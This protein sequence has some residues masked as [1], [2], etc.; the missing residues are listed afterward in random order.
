MS[1]M[2]SLRVIFRYWV[3][4]WVLHYLMWLLSLNFLAFTTSFFL[5]SGTKQQKQACMSSE[6]LLA[7]TIK[8]F[9]TH[10]LMQ[11][12]FWMPWPEIT[13]LKINLPA[14][15]WWRWTITVCCLSSIEGVWSSSQSKFQSI[16][17]LFCVSVKIQRWTYWSN[18][19]ISRSTIGLCR[20]SSFGADLKVFVPFSVPFWRFG[21]RNL[22][23]WSFLIP[24]VI[25]NT[26]NVSKHNILFKWTAI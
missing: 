20:N 26:I 19:G 22:L 1:E 15:N 12:S 16:N 6:K 23:R 25:C 9:C 10:R 24:P 2:Q 18:P 13:S 3:S 5:K 11:V 14:S 4:P 17:I 8:V 21:G 7:R